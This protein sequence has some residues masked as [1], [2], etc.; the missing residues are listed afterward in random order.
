MTLP[1]CV[2]FLLDLETYSILN[3][4]VS[5]KSLLFITVNI[6]RFIYYMDN[7]ELYCYIHIRYSRTSCIDA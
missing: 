3:H 4:T 6:K 7:V 5:I 2:I 1:T